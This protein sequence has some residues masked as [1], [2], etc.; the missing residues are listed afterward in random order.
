[1]NKQNAYNKAVCAQKKIVWNVKNSFII[2]LKIFLNRCRVGK[3]ES[4]NENVFSIVCI[5]KY[6]WVS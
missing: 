1:M 4:K 6:T 3:K 2:L 5:Q